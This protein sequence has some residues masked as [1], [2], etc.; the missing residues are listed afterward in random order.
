MNKSVTT[1]RLQPD[2][3][4][5]VVREAKKWGLSFTDIVNILL[6]A[7]LHG[8]VQIGVTDYPKWYLD[9]IHKE[10]DELRRLSR[11]GKAKTYASA[12]ELFDEL[13]DR[14]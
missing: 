10:A 4:K 14:K 3:R 1:I 2:V 11:Q 6:R 5:A 9:K 8:S 7:Y 13:L 12:K